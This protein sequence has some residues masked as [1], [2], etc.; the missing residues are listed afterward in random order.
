MKTCLGFIFM[1]TEYKKDAPLREKQEAWKSV[2]E[3]EE[4]GLTEGTEVH[5]WRG[6]GSGVIPR[7][8]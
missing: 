6:S 8:P 2:Q 4:E 5:M 1:V 7:S 3:K